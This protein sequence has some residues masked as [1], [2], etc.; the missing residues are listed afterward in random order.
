MKTE[1]FGRWMA[2]MM[3]RNSD[4]AKYG[5]LLNGMVSQFLMNNN[6][7]PVDIRQAKD[8]LSNHMH[9]SHKT[10]RDRSRQKDDKD[11]TTKTNEASFAQSENTKMCYCR[12]KTRHMSQK[13]PEKDKIPRE[14]WAIRKAALHMQAEQTK[15]DEAASQSDKSPKKTGW[16][17]MQ[18]CLMDKKKDISSKMKD[19]IILD[20]GSTLSIFANPE[21]VEGIRQSKSTLKMATNTGMWL[22]NQEANV[23]GF[24]TVWYDEGAIANI[25]SFAELVDKH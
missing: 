16:S 4:Q 11:E 20:N 6:Q 3:I 2:Y 5:S 19:D 15:D 1:A 24:G 25:F 7:Y 22:T 13:C 23:P 21:L 18:V 14:E 12:G 8:I 10:R 9:D 17:G